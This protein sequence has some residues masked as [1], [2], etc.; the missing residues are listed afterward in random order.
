MLP[1]LPEVEFS[2]P[3]VAPIV[4]GVVVC[5][6]GRVLILGAFCVELC[7]GIVTVGIVVSETGP[8]R[9]PVIRQAHR[10][11]ISPRIAAFFIII[12]LKFGFQ[13]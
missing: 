6:L 10:T 12:L 5:V 4:E 2:V 13:S 1:V 7:V 3:E 9:Q 11:I 8:L